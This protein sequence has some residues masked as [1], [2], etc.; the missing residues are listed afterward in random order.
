MDSSEEV[1]R[2]EEGTPPDAVDDEEDAADVLRQQ[3]LERWALQAAAPCSAVQPSADA[4]ALAGVGVSWS[5]TWGIDGWLM[6]SQKRLSLAKLLHPRLAAQSPVFLQGS[7]EV[8]DVLQI[9][10]S[11][12]D[13]CSV[14]YVDHRLARVRSD[15]QD[16][17]KEQF[18]LA[19]ELLRKGAAAQQREADQQREAQQREAALQRV[20]AGAARLDAAQMEHLAAY[21]ES[22]VEDR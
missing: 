5:Q 11:H 1:D 22:L 13:R 7:M 4:P 2:A 12:T 21:A 14:K 3:Q 18:A 15:E 19:Q 17:L 20:P 9:V 8:D 6:A 10:V 16:F